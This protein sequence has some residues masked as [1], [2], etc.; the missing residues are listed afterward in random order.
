M[1]SNTTEI[2]INFTNNTDIYKKANIE[3]GYAFIGC[4]LTIF[5]CIF[6]IALNDYIKYK[7]D[8]DNKPMESKL[9]Y[10]LMYY[11]KMQW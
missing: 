8:P 6:L 11:I 3:L 9:I 2:S 5:A 10:L 7:Y 4:I 1:D